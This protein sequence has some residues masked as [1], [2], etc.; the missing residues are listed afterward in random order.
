[1]QLLQYLLPGLK[2]LLASQPLE[3]DKEILRFTSL[4]YSTLLLFSKFRHGKITSGST[5][6]SQALIKM[7]GITMSG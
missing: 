6:R 5:C 3:D 7:E 1:M 4:T 2:G